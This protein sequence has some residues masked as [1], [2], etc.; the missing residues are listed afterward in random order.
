MDQNLE[1]HEQSSII[2]F[3]L[4]QKRTSLI[5]LVKTSEV[6]S[7]DDASIQLADR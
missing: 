2:F 6:W 7:N 1:D 4:T 5:T 3:K